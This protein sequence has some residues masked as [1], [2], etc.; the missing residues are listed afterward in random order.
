[1]TAMGETDKIKKAKGIIINGVIGLLIIFCAYA[2]SAFIF[3]AL[4][5]QT[6]TPQ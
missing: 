2:L 5:G 1:M 6:T 4:G 3:S